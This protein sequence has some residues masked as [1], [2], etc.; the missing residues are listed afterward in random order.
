L[1]SEPVS[2]ERLSPPPILAGRRRKYRSRFE[3][4]AMVL[5]GAMMGDRKTRLSYRASLSYQQT[6]VYLY[7]LI[8]KG[9]IRLDERTQDFMLTERGLRF[10]RVYQEMIETLSIDGAEEKEGSAGI[11]VWGA[12][13]LAFRQHLRIHADL[14][15]RWL[16]GLALQSIDLEESTTGGNLGMVI[17]VAA[18]CCMLFAIR[19]RTPDVHLSLD[20]RHI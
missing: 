5:R 13:M 2:E 6:L 16:T 8:E 11:P 20:L 7:A 15:G 9:L 3:I 19:R 17:V 1:E 12:L 4:A 14:V 10:L 18:V